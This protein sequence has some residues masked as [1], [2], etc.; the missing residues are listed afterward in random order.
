MNV[1]LIGATSAV[2]QAVAHRYAADG[3]SLYCVARTPEKMSA[4]ADDLGDTLKGSVCYDFTETAQAEAVIE[5]A[6]NTLGQIDVTLIAHGLLPNQAETESRFP[7]VDLTFQV[8]CLSVLSLLSPLCERLK[9]QAHAKVGVITSVAG[10][11]GRPRN[12]TYGAAKGALNLYLQGL[13]SKLWSTT[14]I[15]LYTFKLGPTDS[16]MTIDHEKN[17]T[18]TTPEV[19][20]KAMVRAFT[21]RRYEVYVPGFWRWIM[22][23]VRLMPEWIFQRLKFLSGP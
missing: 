21:K 17:G 23:C 11:R 1:L 10:D 18:F 22:L 3:A 6:F 12:F 7:L 8:N 13:R 16:P 9:A 19:A 5:G 14:A 20:A 4:L 2:A 15:E